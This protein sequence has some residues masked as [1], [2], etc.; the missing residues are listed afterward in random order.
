MRLIVA[1]L[2]AL[3]VTAGGCSF[4]FVQ[5]PKDDYPSREN[6]NC[7]TSPVAP[8]VDTVFTVTNL[9]SAFYVANEDN[10]TNKGPAVGVGLS[11]AAIWLASAIYGYY[12]TSRC[13]D[14]TRDDDVAPYPRHVHLQSAGYRPPPAPLPS[15]AADPASP[16][17][18]QQQDDDD[19]PR[20]RQQ[21]DDDPATGT[22]P[23]HKG[24]PARPDL[25]PRFG[26]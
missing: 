1:V 21:R 23:S 9:L 17:V 12:N 6:T 7:T 15:P 11:V 4:V 25:T 13:A 24:G 19:Q 18:Q 8:V 2:V 3:S 20:A 10:V 5:P 14:L 16:R 26:N 22:G